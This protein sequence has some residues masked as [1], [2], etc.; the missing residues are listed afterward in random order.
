[1]K[2]PCLAA[3][4]TA[5]IVPLARAHEGHGLEGAHWHASDSW[6]FIALAVVLVVA[7]FTKGG[8]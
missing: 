7:W 6:G 3:A 8:R 2:V 1:M 5:L 4:A